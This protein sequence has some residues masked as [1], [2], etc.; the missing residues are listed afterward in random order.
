[1]QEAPST[2]V[3]LLLLTTADMQ[4]QRDDELRRL[5]RSVE[6]FR[7][8][9]PDVPVH[10]LMLLQRCT[11]REAAIGQIGLP[12]W[13]EVVATEQLVPL[14]KAR[15]MMLRQM[16][17]RPDVYRADCVLAYPDDDAWYPDGSLDYI[18]RRFR[19]DAELDFWFCRYGSAAAFEPAPV[20]HHPG[21]QEVIARGS[22]NT[23]VLRGRI[24]KTICGFDE[25]LG[26]GTPA[27]SGE[28]TD[29]AMRA[30][31][32]AKKVSH[33]PYRMVGHRDFDRAIRAKYFGGTLVAL[34][35]H[36]T[37]SASAY[38]AFLR[39]IAVGTA[40]LLKGELSRSDLKA[41][42]QLYGSNQAQIAP[43]IE[44]QRT[45]G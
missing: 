45:I 31:F 3:P 43:G 1:M 12:A 30:F 39:K 26:L 32:A 35:R 6:L 4:A 24:A 9:N 15:N 22:S 25:N 19:D 44:H 23:L 16:A 37:V 11:N 27:K 29:Y 20:E 38:V 14:S 17:Q 10:H 28:D 8:S 18:Y 33:A 36:K 42:W 40:L 41:A 34:G 7:Q 21:L 13:M 5:V 2:A